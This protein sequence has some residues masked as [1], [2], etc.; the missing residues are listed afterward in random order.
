LPREAG[1]FDCAA[2]TCGS[3]FGAFRS[4]EAWPCGAG[5]FRFGVARTGFEWP[6][7]FASCDFD[8]AGELFVRPGAA[9]AGEPCARLPCED[10]WLDFGPALAVECPRPAERAV[11]LCTRPIKAPFVGFDLDFACSVG[12]FDTADPAAGVA[13]RGARPCAA[14]E[15][16]RPDLKSELCCAPA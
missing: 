8:R 9:A 15:A 11:G 7:A 4:F 14:F 16:D 13:A 2:C 6:Y 3:R 12:C 1:C 10:A 5:S